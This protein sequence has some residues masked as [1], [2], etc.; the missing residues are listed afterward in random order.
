MSDFLKD[1]LSDHGP[2]SRSVYFDGKTGQVFFRR[3]SAGQKAELLRG[4]RVQAGLGKSTF[5]IDLAENANSKALLVQFSVCNQD[6]TP[7]FKKLSDVK[8]IDAGVLEVLY[9]AAT[10]VNKDEFV[11]DDAGKA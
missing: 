5:E 7:Y 8:A 6:G 11:G 10:D 3:I 2:V 1:I 4:Q 9:T